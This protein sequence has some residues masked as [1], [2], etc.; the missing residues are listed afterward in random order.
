MAI[1]ATRGVADD[2]HSIAQHAE[3]KH[4]HFAT[5]S[6]HILSLEVGSIK[7]LAGILEVQSVGGR[8][9][10]ALLRI[11]RDW[12]VVNVATLTMRRKNLSPSVLVTSRREGFDI[13]AKSQQPNARIDEQRHLRRD[14]SAL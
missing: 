1:R 8:C 13:M 4:A 7:D 12:Y 5:V 11:V 10:F 2:H 14:R 6:A 3:A 9:A